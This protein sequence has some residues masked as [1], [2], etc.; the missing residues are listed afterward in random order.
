ME[1]I[2]VEMVMMKKKLIVK[3][4]TTQNKRRDWSSMNGD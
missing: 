2:S 3:T 1:C 4:P